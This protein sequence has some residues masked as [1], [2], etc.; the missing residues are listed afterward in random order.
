MLRRKAG[1]STRPFVPTLHRLL[2][3]HTDL[4]TTP[5]E[6]VLSFSRVLDQA[7]AARLIEVVDDGGPVPVWLVG[8]C[9]DALGVRPEFF[10][11]WRLTESWRYDVR[12]VGEDAAIANLSEWA[13]Q[14]GRD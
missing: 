5:E 4:G 14:Q 10:V 9:A 2:R 6:R 8:E 7:S 3:N 12:V 1:V 11:E 13:T